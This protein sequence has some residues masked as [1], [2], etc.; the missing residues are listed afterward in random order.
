MVDYI[1]PCSSHLT[2]Q[3][4]DAMYISTKK[5]VRIYYLKNTI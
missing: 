2:E 3:Q 5:Y 4:A 1:Y